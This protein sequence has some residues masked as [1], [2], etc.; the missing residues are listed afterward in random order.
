MDGLLAATSRSVAGTKKRTRHRN[1]SPGLL[2]SAS[3]LPTRNSRRSRGHR[4]G[5]DARLDKSGAK[6]ESVESTVAGKID[7]LGKKLT[8]CEENEIDKRSSWKFVSRRLKSDK[9]TVAQAPRV[10]PQITEIVGRDRYER[11]GLCDWLQQWTHARRPQ[12]DQCR[13]A[14]AANS[15]PGWRLLRMRRLSAQGGM[16]HRWG[17]VRRSCSNLHRRYVDR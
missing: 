7:H 13:V 14:I 10:L 16:Q 8:K 3:H 1:R 15:I 17:R 2:P 11:L 4:R 9:K 6:I 12:F 5:L